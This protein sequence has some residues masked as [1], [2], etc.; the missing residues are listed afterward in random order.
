MASGKD[1]EE[2]KKTQKE[3]SV[4]VF[5]EY[6]VAVS[7]DLIVKI[8]NGIIKNGWYINLQ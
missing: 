7:F 5:F 1:Q 2:V 3:Y 4:A 8:N 6:S